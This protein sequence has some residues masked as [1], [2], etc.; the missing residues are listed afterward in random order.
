MTLPEYADEDNFI[1]LAHD[2]P[3][4]TQ[5][6]TALLMTRRDLARELLAARNTK[7]GWKFRYDPDQT[8][9]QELRGLGLCTM[10]G[11]T[12]AQ[13]WYLTHFAVV[14]RNRLLQIISTRELEE[15]LENDEVA[16]D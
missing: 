9:I 15:P 11:E 10:D 3:H 13:G 5:Y 4:P 12:R 8:L 16:G 1:W 2:L 6:A 7:T 14:V